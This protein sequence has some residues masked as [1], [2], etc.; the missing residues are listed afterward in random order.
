MNAIVEFR[1]LSME[2]TTRSGRSVLALDDINADIGE[3]EF[4]TIL[5]PSGCGKS[6]LMKI[7]ASVIKPSS[8]EVFFEGRPL[9]APTA[10]IGMVFQQPILMPW[11]N[12]LENVLFPIEMMGKSTKAHEA[13]ARDLLK[14]VGLAGFEKAMPYELSG[15]MQQRAAICRALIY[16]PKLLLMDE[17]FAALD[18]MTREELG[19]ELLR[20]WSERKKTVMFVTH[21]IQEG[22][23]LADRVI[24]MT[25]RPGR[26]ATSIK[27]DLPR[28]RTMNMVSTHEYGRY[29]EEIRSL[30]SGGAQI[31]A[32]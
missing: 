14:L 28:P 21:S 8:G 5:G 2:Y 15:G 1:R 32:E 16:D 23:L 17:P 30:I 19:I 20:I 27:I 18:A 6:T 24:V 22:I 3:N 11:R 10:R 7:V 25:A 13:E 9:T 31:A 26:I 29:A 4:V 12:I